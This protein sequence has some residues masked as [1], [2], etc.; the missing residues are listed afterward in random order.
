MTTSAHS[1][2]LKAVLFD[3]DGT[4]IDSISNIIACWQHTMRQCLDQE[5]TREDILPNVGRTLMD[6]FEEIAPGRSDELL[7]VYRAHQQ[8]IHDETVLP[9]PGTEDTIQAIKRAGLLLGV[10]TSKGIPAAVRG[11]DLFDLQPHLDLLVTHEDTSLHKPNP[12]PL[13]FACERLGIAPAEA[14]YV[15][16]ALWDI[17]A[18]KAAG[19]RTAAV[20]WGAGS[21]EE[22][23]AAG[24]D[25]IFHSM[26]DVL[27]LLP[28]VQ[29][30]R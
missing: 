30:A 8:I 14:I 25:F 27:T 12:D 1:P 3:L 16:D 28:A 22:L 15:G 11:L 9:V 20:T 5:V 29:A 26:K 7:A 10:V 13:I 18:G 4:L 19:V 21:V 24:P 17:Q 6:A 23:S 2:L